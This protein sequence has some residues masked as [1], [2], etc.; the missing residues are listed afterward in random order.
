MVETKL[1]QMVISLAAHYF[2]HA[3]SGNYPYDPVAEISSSKWGAA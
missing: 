2:L 1:R 3:K